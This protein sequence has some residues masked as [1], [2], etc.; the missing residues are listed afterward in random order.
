MQTAC[1]QFWFSDRFTGARNPARLSTKDSIPSNPLRPLS[2]SSYHRSVGSPTGSER[3][4]RSTQLYHV[5]LLREGLASAESVQDLLTALFYLSPD[6]ALR[7]A[8]ELER[9]GR[10]VVITCE[11]EQAE[12]GRDQLRARGAQ[13]IIQAVYARP[14]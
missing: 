7:R 6:A 8:A 1:W 9:K 12:F 14:N 3:Q 13:A 5:V 4:A 10:T 2:L 11:R